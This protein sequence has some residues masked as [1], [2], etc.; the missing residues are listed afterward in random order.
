MAKRVGLLIN[1]IVDLNKKGMKMNRKFMLVGFIGILSGVL[2][3]LFI[4]FVSY[5]PEAETHYHANFAVYV[6]GKQEQFSNPFT[7]EEINE[8]TLSTV[9][10]PKQRVHLHDNIKDVVHVEDEAVTW[11]HL[12][13]SID[14]NISKNYLDTSS[15]V[16]A[17]NDTKKL[18][19]I[20]NGET[21]DDITNKV[22]GDKD[23]LLI[24]YGDST[25]EVLQK[26]YESV[27]ATAEKYD[28]EKDP[29]SCS[30]GHTTNTVKDRLK[31]LF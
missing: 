4:R 29:A 13:Q 3:L 16:L 26:Q 24:S 21:V 20:L 15:V 9:K 1:S 30:A 18:I 7:Y 11:G 2:L 14:W 25:K 5:K 8:C 12:F 10:K 31:H 22:I 19:F 6:D 27:P 17:N 28:M 23:K